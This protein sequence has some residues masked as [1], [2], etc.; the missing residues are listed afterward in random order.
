VAEQL[1]FLLI[2]SVK[3]LCFPKAEAGEVNWTNANPVRVTHLILPTGV[4]PGELFLY[5]IVDVTGRDCLTAPF[6]AYLLS[7]GEYSK[8]VAEWVSRPIER[9]AE[10]SPERIRLDL[11]TLFPGQSLRVRYRATRDITMVM[12]LVESKLLGAAP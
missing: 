8:R 12:Y 10:E 4:D 1:G 7:D 9:S 11:P 6:D 3:V 2:D 5:Q